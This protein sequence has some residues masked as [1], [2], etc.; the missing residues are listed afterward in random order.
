M[1]PPSECGLIHIS[2][3]REGRHSIFMDQSERRV[4]IEKIVGKNEDDLKELLQ[5]ANVPKLSAV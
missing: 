2:T 1:W 5:A 4:M 3:V